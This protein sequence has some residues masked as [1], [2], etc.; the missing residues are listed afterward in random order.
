MKLS[1][2]QMT[3]SE[4]A[5][6][7]LALRPLRSADKLQFKLKK[8]GEAKK[9]TVRAVKKSKLTTLDP[10]KLSPAQLAELRKLLESSL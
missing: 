4:A 7:V 9:T 1:L 10:T 6:V 3:V 8:E 2:T 5:S